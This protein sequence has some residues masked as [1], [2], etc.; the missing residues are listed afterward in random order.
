MY[1]KVYLD[2]AAMST[3]HEKYFRLET[4]IVYSFPP[5]WSKDFGKSPGD[6]NDEGFSIIIHDILIEY[7]W[8]ANET[9]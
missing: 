4:Q 9:I 6:I 7:D 3:I 8:N 5:F 1:E 2:G